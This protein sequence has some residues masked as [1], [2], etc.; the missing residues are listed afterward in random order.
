MGASQ[1]PAED[2][3]DT[4]PDVRRHLDQHGK[5]IG[6]LERGQRATHKEIKTLHD[7][8]DRIQISLTG[9][10]GEYA[11]AARHII[12]VDQKLDA[13]ARILH[14][15][16][17]KMGELSAN[18]ISQKAICDDRHGDIDRKFESL[19]D[20]DDVLKVDTSVFE[21]MSG[22]QVKEMIAEEKRQREALQEEVIKMQQRDAIHQAQK[23]AVSDA[24]KRWED[25]LVKTEQDQKKALEE[26]NKTKIARY[27]MYGTIGVAIIAAAATITK[28]FLDNGDT[29]HGRPRTHQTHEVEK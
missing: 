29:G 28:A 27:T 12:S 1:A 19:T 24:K 2:M 15:V 14:G 9:L 18:M 3:P 26:A 16:F 25:G 6:A 23:Q 17:E 11:T 10:T 5:A 4:Y 22:S 20:E 8:I 7:K 13:N 21:E